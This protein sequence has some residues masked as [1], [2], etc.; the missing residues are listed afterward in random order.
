MSI[1]DID[2]SSCNL[3]PEYNQLKIK[4]TKQQEALQQS[5]YKQQELNK[6]LCYVKQQMKGVKNWTELE[7]TVVCIF[8]FFFFYSVLSFHVII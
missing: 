2:C 7:K 3:K 5:V 6:Q 8:F 4:M 1:Y